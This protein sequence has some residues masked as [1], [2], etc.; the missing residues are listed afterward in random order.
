MKITETKI[1]IGDLYL[2]YKDDGEGGV[3]AYNGKLTVRPSYQREFVYSDDKRDAVINTVRQNFPLNIMY[4]SK[5][6]DDTYEVLDGQQRTISICRYLAGDF[7]INHKYFHSL[8][9]AEQQQIKDYELTVYICEGSEKEKLAW[10][11]II[12][13]A[14]AVLTKQELL[15]ATYTGPWLAD[16][17]RHFSKTNCP[18]KGLSDGYMKGAAIRQEYLER[19]LKWISDRDGLK[20]HEEY[21]SKHQHDDDASDLWTYFQTVIN[22]AKMLFPKR[23][24]KLYAAQEWGF[25]YN[26]YHDNKY[27]PN[28]LEREVSKLMLDDDVTKKSGIIEYVLSEK[29]PN[30]EKHL[31]LRTFS[32]SQKLKAYERQ[33]HKCPLCQK[34]G[35][36]DEY[37]FE[38]MQGDHII[39]WSRGGTTTD[40]NLQM[41]CRDCNNGKS[42]K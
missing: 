37:A 1:T 4:W 36:E 32:D 13:I 9:A 23:N 7:S 10:F 24:P 38:D 33:K 26:K 3:Y 41:L 8:T 22:W 14:G 16:A 19:V 39:P 15:N 31:S 6:G 42:D 40:D 20:N 35:I 34:K 18:A 2:N 11:E 25:L 30:D 29:K 21:M 5:T 28:E 12:N 17:K 27:N